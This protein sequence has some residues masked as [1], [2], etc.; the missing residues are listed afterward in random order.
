MLHSVMLDLLHVWGGYVHMCS[1][2]HGMCARMSMSMPEVNY[3]VYSHCLHYF[4]RQG[5]SLTLEF[6]NSTRLSA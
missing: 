2:A 1:P 5:L 4:L 6:T 3:C